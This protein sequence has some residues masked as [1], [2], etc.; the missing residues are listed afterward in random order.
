LDVGSGSGI[1]S[2]GAA[3]LGA[4]RVMGVEIDRVALKAGRANLRSNGVSGRVRF[5]AGTLP[6]EH[7]TVDWADLVLANVN[8]VA[9]AKLAPE[10]RA[11]VKPNGHLIAAGILKERREQVM[12]AF[13]ESRISLVEEHHDEDWVTL[14]CIPA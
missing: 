1:L 13:N 6:N 7:I 12:R 9:L 5:Y 4:E 14:V 10:L 3:K 8:S 2:I 11:A